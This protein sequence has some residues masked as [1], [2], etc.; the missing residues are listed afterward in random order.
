MGKPCVI[1]GGKFMW[2]ETQSI[3][4]HLDINKIV[5][6]VF[7]CGGCG[8]LFI[9]DKNSKNP[10]KMQRKGLPE[11]T[12]SIIKNT[13]EEERIFGKIWIESDGKY[14]VK[15]KDY[16]DSIIKVKVKRKKK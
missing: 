3:T 15:P 5:V 7:R 14:G 11:Y 10:N 12:P 4:S 13:P 1:C 8:K 9:V 6:D 16:V 2:L